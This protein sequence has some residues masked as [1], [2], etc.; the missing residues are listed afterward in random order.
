MGSDRGEFW[1]RTL[2][3]SLFGHQSLFV[4]PVAMGLPAPSRIGRAVSVD[5]FCSSLAIF[6]SS[7]ILVQRLAS[8]LSTLLLARTFLFAPTP[9]ASDLE[10]RGRWPRIRFSA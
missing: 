10:W 1:R 3:S 8:S 6:L 5:K 4:G 2:R 7:L 9:A